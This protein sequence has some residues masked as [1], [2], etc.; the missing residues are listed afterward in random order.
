MLTVRG[1]LAKSKR[2]EDRIGQFPYSRL[3]AEMLDDEEIT[4]M[5][6]PKN[7]SHF[8]A[9][10][11]RRREVLCGRPGAPCD[12]ERFCRR[13]ERQEQVQEPVQEHVKEEGEEE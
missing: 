10:S 5:I 12:I 1:E 11:Q 13:G 3:E 9:S 2:I 4:Q 7:T 6:M 8:A